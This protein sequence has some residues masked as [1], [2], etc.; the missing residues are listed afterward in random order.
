MVYVGEQ[1][2]GYRYINGCFYIVFNCKKFNGTMQEAK[3]KAFKHLRNILYQN[4]NFI[5]YEDT[6]RYFCYISK[7]PLDTDYIYEW[8]YKKLRM[9]EKEI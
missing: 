8:D 9:Y 3:E 7:E 2:K 1:A 5:L 4:D 6:N